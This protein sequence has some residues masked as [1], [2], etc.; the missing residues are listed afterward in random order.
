MSRKTYIFDLEDEMRKQ[1][2]LESLRDRKNISADAGIEDKKTENDSDDGQ[3]QKYLR[4][5]RRLP[6]VGNNVISE[7]EME[8]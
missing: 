5:G 6:S 7:Q 1:N 4:F 2:P 8:F 3:P